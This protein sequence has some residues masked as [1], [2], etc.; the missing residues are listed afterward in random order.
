M[1]AEKLEAKGVKVS[2]MDLA[3]EDWAEAIE[4]AFRYDRVVFATT[5][6]NNDVFPFTK[7][8]LE[9]LAVRGYQNRKIGIIENSTW[10]PAVEKGV[11]K[12]LEGGK[13]I[14]FCETVVSIKSA[15]D[16]ENIKQIEMLAEE[17]T[18]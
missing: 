16:D 9:H 10:A 12:M 2:V 1:L 11:K 18:K 14:E 17:L 13:D 6:Y 4:D 3:R 15:M 7:T 5:T 8:L